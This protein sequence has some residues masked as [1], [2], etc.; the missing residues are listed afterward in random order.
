MLAQHINNPEKMSLK[1]LIVLTI[2]CCYCHLGVTWPA[3]L[4]GKLTENHNIVKP[5]FLG[6]FYY[7]NSNKTYMVSSTNTSWFDAYIICQQY[8]MELATVESQQEETQLDEILKSERT[9][10]S[11]YHSH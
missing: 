1:L 4:T 5:I 2:L 6:L 9:P 3:N 11:W 10:R 7:T 8:N